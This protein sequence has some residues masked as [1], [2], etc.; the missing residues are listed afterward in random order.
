MK[1]VRMYCTATCPYCQ[2]A[3]RLLLRKGAVI[4]KIRVDLQPEL[5]ETMEAET[6]RDTV[7]QIFIGG[8]HVGGFDDM[9]ELD[10]EG[11]LD[12]LLESD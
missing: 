1:P 6:G 11:E 3:E 10:M 8:H 4:E 12:A 9:V 7:P 5:W 2:K